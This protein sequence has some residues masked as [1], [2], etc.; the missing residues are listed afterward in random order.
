M[1]RV[2]LI[3]FYTC[4]QSA[5]QVLRKKGCIYPNYIVPTKITL[6]YLLLV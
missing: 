3:N 5:I 6:S 1:L 2:L 4:M